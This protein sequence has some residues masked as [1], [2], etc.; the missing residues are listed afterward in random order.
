MAKRPPGWKI[1][2]DV[3][4]K[5]FSTGGVIAVEDDD[6][7]IH[8]D[9]SS[10]LAL[11]TS[12]DDLDF[13]TL[14]IDGQSMDV[15]APPDIIDVDEDD[16]SIDYEDALPHDLADSDDEDLAN[17]DD[18][19][20][21]AVAEARAPENPTGEAGKPADSILA[22]KPGPSGYERLRIN[23]ARRRS[24][25]SGMIEACSCL[26]VTTRLIGVTSLGRSSGIYW[27]CCT[28]QIP[29]IGKIKK[30]IEQHLA[31]IYTDN[32]SALKA[33][34]WVPNPDDGTYDVEGV[35]SSPMQIG[36][37]NLPFGL[38]PK[39]LPGMLKMLETGQR[40]RSYSGRD[41]GHLL[42]SKICSSET[43][44]YP[45]LIQ[46]YYDTHTVDSV[47]LRD[48][49]RLL[50]EEMLRLHGLG[51]NTPTGVPYTDDEIMAIVHRGKQW[52]NLPSVGRVLAG[53][54]RDVV[55]SDDRMSQLLTQLQSQNKV[56]SGSGSGEG[57]DDDNA[58]EDE[59]ADGDED[60]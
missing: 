55:R 39:T 1:V 11:S 16:D 35:R 37:R 60:S 27:F 20:V 45:S 19:V 49:E 41:P 46:T 3:N 21:A 17:D 6:D 36:M 33:E 51:P 28:W 54:G 24:S 9:K 15:N 59:D 22:G 57:G 2:Q 29:T 18:D 23:W 43:R 34:H 44:E 42:S 8:F 48:E 40:A 4:H 10:T 25:L 47:F 38:I 50:Y 56:G 30:G 26:S 12:L 13:A 58:G 52:G 32:K 31:K 5:K 53:Q 14:N 7:V